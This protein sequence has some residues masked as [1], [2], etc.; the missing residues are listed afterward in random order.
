MAK[1]QD[2]TCYLCESP[3]SAIDPDTTANHLIPPRASLQSSSEL[4]C[5]MCQIAV[6]TLA[7]WTVRARLPQLQR[8][9]DEVR[10]HFNMIAGTL[11]DQ[12]PDEARQIR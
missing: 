2:T 4:I 7:Q 1:T 5:P 11:K 10:A 9:V 6:S 8:L 12:R 3:I